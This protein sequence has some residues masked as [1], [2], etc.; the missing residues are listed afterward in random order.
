MLRGGRGTAKSAKRERDHDP[1]FSGELRDRL[2][3]A[4]ENLNLFRI[5]G[6][7]FRICFLRVFARNRKR[8]PRM[9]TDSLAHIPGDGGGVVRDFLERR[10]G[11]DNKS[12]RYFTRRVMFA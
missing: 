3:V 5:S 7:E 9:D 4:F 1:T 12:R 2:I 6:L 11:S 10:G 8:K